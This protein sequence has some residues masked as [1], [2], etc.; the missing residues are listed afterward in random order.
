MGNNI[1]NAIILVLSFC[2]LFAILFLIISS[3]PRH[4]RKH[5]ENI[6]DEPP[7][8]EYQSQLIDLRED[9]LKSDFE[10][11]N[12][13]KR[14]I[15]QSKQAG[16]NI[17]V[18]GELLER[19]RQV[20]ATGV[21]FVAEKGYEVILKNLNTAKN[22]LVANGDP[23]FLEPEV[24]IEAIEQGLNRNEKIIEKL[25]SLSLEIVKIVNNSQQTDV[26]TQIDL[27]TSTVKK[28]NAPSP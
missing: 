4:I 11:S 1:V 23:D 7:F 26:E 24:S 25:N 9:L 5:K 16:S 17:V 12:L 18:L 28:I 2:M 27:L 10:D 8:W 20:Y 13:A 21:S 6:A 14:I 3:I 15:I 22:L 19:H